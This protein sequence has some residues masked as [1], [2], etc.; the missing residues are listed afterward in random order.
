MN[1][2]DVVEDSNGEDEVTYA[3]YRLRTEDDG[4]R[5]RR[6]ISRLYDVDVNSHFD[7]PESFKIVPDVETASRIWCKAMDYNEVE[8]RLFGNAEKSG[9]EIIPE[10]ILKC[11]ADIVGFTKEKIKNLLGRTDDNNYHI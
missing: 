7:F 9:R 4:E 1:A 10:Y 3:D 5:L 8:R 6:N 2:S 11:F